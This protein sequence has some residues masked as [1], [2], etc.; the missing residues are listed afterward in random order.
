MLL[1]EVK[2]VFLIREV[3]LEVLEGG[4]EISFLENLVNQ[5]LVQVSASQDVEQGVLLVLFLLH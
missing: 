3:L 4:L 2:Y 5:L 1:L